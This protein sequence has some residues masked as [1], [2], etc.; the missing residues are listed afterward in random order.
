MSGKTLPSALLA[1]LASAVVLTGCGSDDSTDGATTS[2]SASAAPTTP[3]ADTPAGEHNDADIAFAQEM[4]AHHRQAVMMATMVPSRSTDPQV[5]ALAQ[6]IEGAQEPEIATMTAWLQAWG[7]PVTAGHDGSGHDGSG[8][9]ADSSMPGMMSDEQM[10]QME[11]AGGPEFD[12]MWLTG[13]IAHHEGAIVMS[14]TELAEGAD[15]AAKAMAQQIIDAQQAEIDEMR[16]MLQ[17]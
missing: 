7:V 2:V 1:V 17:G 4:I 16:T 14:R 9:G 6:R 8:H 11:A 13:M 15:P 12:R 3:G 5:L 10:S